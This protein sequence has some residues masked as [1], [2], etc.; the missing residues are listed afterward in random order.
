VDY[1]SAHKTMAIPEL[2]WLHFDD[3]G[4]S[5]DVRSYWGT[6]ANNTKAA[7]EQAAREHNKLKVLALLGMSLHAVQDFYT[8]S[9]WVEVRGTTGQ[10]AYDCT[11]FFDAPFTPGLRTGAYPNSDPIKP[12]DHG[13]YDAGMNHDSYGRPGWSRAYI[14]AYAASVQWVSSVRNWVNKVDPELWD[15]L[16]SLTLESKDRAA[17][18]VDAAA[19]YKI[20]EWVKSEE[21]NGH[22][23]G[24][25]SGSKAEFYTYV[26]GYS[27]RVDSIF[28]EHFK[29]DKWYLPLVIGLKKPS[30]VPTFPP[31]S[32]V[33]ME[34]VAIFVRTLWVEELPVG[35]KESKIDP[36]G[37]PDFYARVQIDNALSVEAM[38]VDRS[39]FASS[40]TTIT[41]VPKK[42][43]TVK[44]SYKLLDE[45][46]GNGSNDDTCDI[47]PD[48]TK[49]DLDFTLD[50]ATEM[51][52]GDLKGLHN[53]PETGVYSEGAAPQSDRAR[54]Q[55]MVTARPLTRS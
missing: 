3:L 41:F 17:L 45:D 25:G 44:I 27:E 1:Y 24:Q 52:S 14:Y 10:G 32:G 4:S 48:K 19:S 35:E 23:K 2:A 49:R 16:R 46:S 21:H 54:V 29:N 8:H 18:A 51:L 20:S 47:N 12:T 9:N 55:L 37:T 6:L 43:A 42:Q 28:V 50:L 53:T 5:A 22:W 11:T 33:P 40:W 34:R 13:G 36:G 39:R 15:D 30:S 7:V 26:T 38:Q 31:L